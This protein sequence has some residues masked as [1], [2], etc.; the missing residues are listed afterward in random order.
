[1]RTAA[2]LSGSFNSPT[3]PPPAPEGITQANTAPTLPWPDRPAMEAAFADLRAT[4]GDQHY[5]YVLQVH[6]VS[7]DLKGKTGK[8]AEA[9]SVLRLRATEIATGVPV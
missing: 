1:M 9:Y 3:L 4:V 8:I 2:L 5:F 6:G 7:P